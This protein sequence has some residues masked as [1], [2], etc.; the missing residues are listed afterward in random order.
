MLKTEFHKEEQTVNGQLKSKNTHSPININD[1]LSLLEPT[2]LTLFWVIIYSEMTVLALI[3][4]AI[5]IAKKP[6]K[7][8]SGAYSE[9]GG[10][11]T[12]KLSS[13]DTTQ[14]TI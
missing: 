11:M 1:A 12:P 9:A 7:Q 5:V 3:L 8:T 6:N 10:F 14:D 2:I 4:L 13:E